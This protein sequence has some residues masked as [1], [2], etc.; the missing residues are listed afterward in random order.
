[1]LE[2]LE[3]SLEMGLMG[4]YRAWS[5]LCKVSEDFCWGGELRVDKMCGSECVEWQD[6]MNEVLR[7]GK[8]AS[9]GSLD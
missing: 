9:G 7:M 3:V 4:V 5:I 8:G 1:M 6:F 2:V